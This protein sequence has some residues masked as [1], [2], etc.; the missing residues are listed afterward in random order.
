MGGDSLGLRNAGYD[1]V[2]YS[3]KEKEFQKSHNLN[4][5]D[6]TLLGNGDITKTIDE[7]FLEYENHWKF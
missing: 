2:A 5:R 6:C 4:F 1:L 7:E 3:E